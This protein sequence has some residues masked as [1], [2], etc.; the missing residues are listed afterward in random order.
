MTE[1]AKDAFA[2]AKGVVPFQDVTKAVNDMR[3]L[4]RDH[5]VFLS[6]CW[7]SGVLPVY[8][9]RALHPT[10]GSDI[11]KLVDRRNRVN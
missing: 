3:S 5:H 6:I 11:A 2:A 1:E 4:G 9:G 8:M 7:L 10:P